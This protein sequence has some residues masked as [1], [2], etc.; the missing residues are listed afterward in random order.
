M[1]CDAII[2]SQ[3]ALW[4]EDKSFLLWEI[5]RRCVIEHWM[6]V[7]F[8]S[9]A[10]LRLWLEEPDEDLFSFVSET[11]PLNR[12]VHVQTGAPASRPEACTFLDSK[13]GIIIRRGPQLTP[14]LPRQAPART[15]FAMVRN[16]LLELHTHG[17]QTPELESQMSPG[18]FVGHHCSI[19][20]DTV[21]LPPCWVGSG[22]TIVGAT[23]G[24]Y[25]AVGENCVITGGGRITDSYLLGG[26]YVA[27]GMQ[28]TGVAAGPTG[29]IAHA[30]GSRIILS[31]PVQKG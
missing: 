16:W 25:T 13:G 27:P 29:I 22:S 2:P 7:L 15:W 12:R 30:T 18:V 20:K 5:G 21:F 3:P 24:P 8:R 23:I 14:Y 6:D 26:T 28:M 9:N 17:S 11:F 10:T 19:S 1:I 4:L 31:P